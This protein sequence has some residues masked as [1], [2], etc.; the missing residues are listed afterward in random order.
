MDILCFRRFSNRQS[1]CFVRHRSRQS[2]ADA[3]PHFV[4]REQTPRPRPARAVTACRRSVR[5]TRRRKRL[6]TPIVRFST[7]ITDTTSNYTRFVFVSIARRCRIDVRLAST[8]PFLLRPPCSRVIALSWRAVRRES[9]NRKQRVSTLARESDCWHAIPLTRTKCVFRWF[10]NC[11]RHP[12]CARNCRE[13]RAKRSATC[14]E[15]NNSVTETKD[16][17]TIRTK[18][19]QNTTERRSYSVTWP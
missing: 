16:L 11:S 18:L 10:W 5:T 2:H 17:T 3:L 6:F 15:L 13:C 19:V 9:L 7:E 8:S 4:V 12:C 1:T 14:S